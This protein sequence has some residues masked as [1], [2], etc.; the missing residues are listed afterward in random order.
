MQ[1]ARINGRGAMEVMAALR[2]HLQGV[3]MVGL[4]EEEGE[5]E[6]TQCEGT[7]ALW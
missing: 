2:W 7:M 6:P 1:N 5:E 3:G 4:L